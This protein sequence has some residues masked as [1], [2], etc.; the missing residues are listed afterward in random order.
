MS[1]SGDRVKSAAGAAQAYRLR[2]AADWTM[3]PDNCIS[4]GIAGRC[5]TSAEQHVVAIS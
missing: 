3:S 4:S 1:K 5:A 2:S